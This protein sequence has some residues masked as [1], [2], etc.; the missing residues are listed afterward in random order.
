MTEP[1]ASAALLHCVHAQHRGFDCS[2]TT[3]GAAILG[4]FVFLVAFIAVLMILR[5]G[6]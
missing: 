4:Y 5:R 1:L 3:S 6:R 2:M